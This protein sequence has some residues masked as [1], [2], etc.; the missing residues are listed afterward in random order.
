MA[1]IDEFK[2]LFDEWIAA[3]TDAVDAAAARLVRSRRIQLEEGED[4]TLKANAVA[5]KNGPALPDVSF[6]LDNGSANPPLS[7]DWAAAFRCSRVE[8][9]L[10]SGNVMVSRLDF[11]SQAGHFLDGMIRAQ[12]DRLTPWTANDAVFGWSPPTTGANERIEV[13]LAA[14]S[15][16]A[17]QPLLQFVRAAGAASVAVHAYS[18]P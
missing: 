5:V 3:V 1:L 6:R 13:T 7:A 12:I 11:P 16:L 2:Q 10:Q 14:T 4:G 15:K 8:A 17:V 9:Q 18:A